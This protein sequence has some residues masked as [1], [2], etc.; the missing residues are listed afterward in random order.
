MD[1]FEEAKQ[2]SRVPLFAGL[3]SAKL[4]LLAFTSQQL[5]FSDGDYLFHLD[6]PSDSVY[7]LMQGVMQIVVEHE[8]GHVEPILDRHANDL[9]GEMGV[10]ANTPRS[11]S[12]RAAGPVVALKIESDVFM[13]LLTENPSMSLFVMRELTT[14]LN[15]YV[16]REREQ[17]LA[18]SEKNES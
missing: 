2:L 8:D 17:A 12:V 1:V 10:I 15:Q 5:N 11:A 9:I 16:T 3:D 4:K 6:D 14:R 13:T 18:Q 7:L